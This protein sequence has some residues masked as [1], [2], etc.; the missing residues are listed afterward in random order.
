MRISWATGGGFGGKALDGDRLI[1]FENFSR[2][3]SSSSLSSGFRR[4]LLGRYVLF[5]EVD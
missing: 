1:L 4:G 5:A 3:A 2:R